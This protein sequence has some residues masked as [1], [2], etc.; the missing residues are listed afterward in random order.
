MIYVLYRSFGIANLN[1][2]MASLR[3]SLLDLDAG[4][5]AKRAAYRFGS[6]VNPNSNAPIMLRNRGPP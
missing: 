3:K 1:R 2:W 4:D 6:I 5:P